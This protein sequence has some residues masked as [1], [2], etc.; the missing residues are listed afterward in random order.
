MLAA[1]ITIGAGACGNTDAWVDASAAQGWPAQYADAANSS[2][3][4]TDGATKLSLQ[5]TR[6]VKGSL[7][8]GPALSARCCCS[9]IPSASTPPRFAR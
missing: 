3:T 1:A 5:W 9:P 4:A 2:Y 7:A 8:A 6:S